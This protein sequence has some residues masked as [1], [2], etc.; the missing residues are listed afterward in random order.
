M[1]M[2]GID[3]SCNELTRGIPP[4]M[5]NLIMLISLNLS[6]NNLVGPIPL[7]FSNLNQIE[8]LNGK[9]PPK[10]VDIV[11]VSVFTVAHDNLSGKTPGY[12][13]QFGTFDNGSYEGNPLLCGRPLSKVCN[14]IEQ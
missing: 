9:I 5:G 13:L 11:T 3:L 2:L 10:L 7:E 14:E 1:F 4:Q 12:I 6:H 8:S